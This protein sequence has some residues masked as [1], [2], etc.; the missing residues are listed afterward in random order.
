MDMKIYATSNIYDMGTK[1]YATA[2]KSF[3]IKCRVIK[4]DEPNGL[5]FVPYG[6]Y[7]RRN[8][9]FDDLSKQI[10]QFTVHWSVTYTA[11]SMFSGLNARKLSTNFMIDD[12]NNNGYATIYQNLPIMSGAW[13]QGD[14]FNN[15]GPGVEIAYMPQA[16]EKD[17]YSL[18][19]RTKN[20]VPA[21]DTTTVSVHGTKLKVFLPTKA[22][23]ASLI[24]LIWGFVELFPNVPAK[25]PRTNQG[26]FMTTQ[27]TNPVQYN[28]LV[29]HYHLR[30][31]KIDAAGIDY[32]LIEDEVAKRRKVGF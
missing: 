21:H 8:I 10:K 15:L 32:Q 30:R 27:L 25:F 4:W 31:E 28:G 22:Q 20:G 9:S 7:N 26:Y 11:K 14:K 17:M 19:A 24:Q 29:S 6:N 1:I 3:D 16:W 5:N 2:E 18:I 23:M 12:D 13:S